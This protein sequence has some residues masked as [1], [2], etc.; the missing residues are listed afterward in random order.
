[1]KRIALV[2][3]QN[4][5]NEQEYE[6]VFDAFEAEDF[7]ISVVSESVGQAVGKNGKIINADFSLGSII[8]GN[9]DAIVFIGGHGARELVHNSSAMHLIKDA[10]S[11]NKIVAAICIAPIILAF[12]G[13]LEGKKATVS[14]GGV[15]ILVN[16]GA[17]YVDRD[18]VVDGNIITGS[19]PDASIDFANKIIEELQNGES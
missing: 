17:E 6:D 3:A 2:V 8:V 13:I 19:G 14:S 4:E 9:Y 18:V 1:M 10:Y 7:N 15:D 5:F 12:A 11:Q 16:K